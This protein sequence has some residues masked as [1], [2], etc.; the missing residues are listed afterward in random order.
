[1]PLEFDPSWRFEAPPGEVPNELVDEF[2]KLIARIATHRPGQSTLEHFKGYFAAAAGTTSTRSSNPGWAQSDLDS[3][4]QRASR[5]VP[6]FIAAFF[7]GCEALRREGV[8]VP[9][10]DLINRL[11][12][13]NEVPYG[14][15]PPELIFV[16][17]GVAPVAI[18]DTTPSLDEQ[19]FEVLQNA[20]STSEQLLAGGKG[21][22]AVQE[23]LWVLETITTAFR[24]LDTE[25][26]TVRGKYFNKILADLRTQNKGTHLRQVVSWA[27]KLHGYL[28]SP[29]GG[30][31]RHGA[32]VAAL[33]PLQLHEA[34][35][36]CNLIRSYASFLI[37][38]H[39][40]H[41]E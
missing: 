3:Y 15:D 27:L 2:S 6:L 16:G 20:I 28:S 14:I 9:K 38:E 26:G 33:Q 22:Q 18:Q 40:R 29:T 39:T 41:A 21:R 34:R 10:V 1:M 35:L 19:A 24:G 7:D 12:A 13:E 8:D 36:F 32:D 23:M 17:Q 30:A 25:T 11:I 4:M 31:I 37:D 5:N